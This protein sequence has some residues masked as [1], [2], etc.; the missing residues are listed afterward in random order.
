M[1]TIKVARGNPTAE[2]LAAVLVVLHARAV[3]APATT[4]D[5]EPAALDAWADKG[6][7]TKPW[8][9]PDA[10]RTTYWPR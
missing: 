5:A 4:T 7:T 2:E 1:T 9:G 6:R 3:S 8:P 10:W